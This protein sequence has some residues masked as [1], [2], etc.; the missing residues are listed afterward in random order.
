MWTHPVQCGIVCIVFGSN[1]QPGKAMKHHKYKT[2]RWKVH[3]GSTS[4]LTGFNIELY[5]KL[6]L[7]LK[8]KE[9]IVSVTNSC[10]CHNQLKLHGNNRQQWLDRSSICGN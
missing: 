3:E 1:T 6:F 10:E 7:Y 2:A 5:V 4:K 8:T 9:D